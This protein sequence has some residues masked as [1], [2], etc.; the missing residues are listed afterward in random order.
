MLSFVSRGQE[1]KYFVVN[2]TKS[3]QNIDPVM[4]REE[5]SSGRSFFFLFGAGI[6]PI[7]H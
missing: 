5:L 1:N 7:I 2:S 6:P 4:N 3:L